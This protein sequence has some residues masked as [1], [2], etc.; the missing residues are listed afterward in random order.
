M[1][2]S[3][4][5]DLV[6][7]LFCAIE[8]ALEPLDVDFDQTEG[9]LN[10]ECVDRSMIILSRQA[11]TREIWIA[12]RSGGYHLA[13]TSG[14]WT[15]SKTDESLQRLLERVLGEQMGEAIKLELEIR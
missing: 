2:E 7:Q 4:F 8:D 3:E 5:N 9:V 6:D 11:A 13:L 14:I 10:I 15:C 12:A 1:T